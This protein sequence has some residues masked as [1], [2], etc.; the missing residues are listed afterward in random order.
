MSKKRA[1]KKEEQ[2]YLNILEDILFEGCKKPCAL[3]NSEHNTYSLHGVKMEF[4]LMSNGKRII[5]LLTSKRVS[6]RLVL[7]EL[8]WFLSGSTSAKELADKYSNHIW[9]ANADE[10]GELGPIYGHQWRS[11][12]APCDESESENES[13]EISVPT[14][15]EESQ[16]ECEYIDQIETVIA[17][18]KED[19]ENNSFSRRHI[20]SA[21]NPDQLDEMALPPCHV[22]F[23]FL[24]RPDRDSGAPVLDCLLYQRSGDFP[25]GVPFNI[26]SYSLLT[27]M[28]SQIINATPGKFI[29][30][31]GDA[32]IYENQIPGCKLQL[33]KPVGRFPV[34]NM[35]RRESIDD[36]GYDDFE[37]SGYKHAGT[38][39]FPL[40]V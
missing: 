5:P 37:I 13:D 18:L 6:F 12:N 16:S 11:W 35:K 19:I 28:I 26:A 40:N 8:L 7:T 21:W 25:L 27:H 1:N 20:V 39:D 33:E 4:S 34:L 23:H 32:H 30:F 29:H 38:I 24:L 31:I 22:L 2:Q 14:S 17:G 10:E 9:D 36:F 3:G 15:E